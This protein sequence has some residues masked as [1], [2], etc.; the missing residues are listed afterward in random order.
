MEILFGIF[1]LYLLVNVGCRN[2]KLKFGIIYGW[3]VFGRESGGVVFFRIV[4]G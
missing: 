2:N 1:S 3:F 4:C